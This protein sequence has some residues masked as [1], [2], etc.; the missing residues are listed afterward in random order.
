M[1]YVIG[2]ACVA[3][4]TCQSACPVEAISEDKPDM[5]DNDKCIACMRC[6]SLCP[7][8][9]RYLAPEIIEVFTEKLSA[10]ATERKQNSLY[11]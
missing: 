9:T 11:L 6:I 4:G 2:D 3:C 10:V 7:N 8:Q 1:A 5:T